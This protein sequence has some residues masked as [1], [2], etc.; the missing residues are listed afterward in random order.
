VLADFERPG[1]VAFHYCSEKIPERRIE[2][3]RTVFREDAGPD[4][5]RIL[6]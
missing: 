1:F 2:D 6:S 3:V 5:A 4:V